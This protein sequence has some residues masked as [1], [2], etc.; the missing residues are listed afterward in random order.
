MKDEIINS[1]YSGTPL[2]KKLGVKEGFSLRLKNAPED[3]LNWL[4]PLPN[5]L[6]INDSNELD[7]IISFNESVDSLELLLN[8]DIPCLKKSGMLWVC[9]P[10]GSSGRVTDLNRDV[11]RTYFLDFG[12]VDV[13]IASISEVWSGL[14]FV[15][16]LKDR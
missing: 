12:L 4:E 16:R 13:K 11:I 7:I 8:K 9:W 5:A 15:Y 10:K 6:V 3:F 14:K 2:N 1:G